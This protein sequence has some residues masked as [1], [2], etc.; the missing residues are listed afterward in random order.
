MSNGFKK[1][2]TFA[3]A[4]AGVYAVSKYLRNYTDYRLADQDDLDEL[5]NG[6]EKAKEAAKRTY[7]AIR[8]G[9]D[10]NEPVGEL[11]SAV[12]GIAENAGRVISSVGSNAREFAIKEK[13]KY[14]EDP[15]AYRAQVAENLKDLR[16]QTADLISG[17]KEDAQ[18]AFSEFRE[19][20]VYSGSDNDGDT[21]DFVTEQET[22][23]DENAES[24]AG[25]IYAD[26]TP[27][28]PETTG[29][30]R[31]NTG[32]SADITEAELNETA[33]YSAGTA[34]ENGSAEYAAETDGNT[35]ADPGEKACIL[36]E[37]L[38]VSEDSDT[39]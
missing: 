14:T 17:L 15:A 35:A 10:V 7:I 36:N 11:G 8:T 19:N 34:E 37:T 6:G 5:K 21:E 27:S 31:D 20:M 16:Q 12:A 29:T 33:E 24:A 22:D 39:F 4:A 23:A 28:S 25:K 13:E 38:S 1:L 9:S 32:E 3:A 2:L 18:T 30:D 26:I